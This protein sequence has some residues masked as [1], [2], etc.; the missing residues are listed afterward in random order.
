MKKLILVT[1]AIVCFT[2]FSCDSPARFDQP[3]P[4]GE[5]ILSSIPFQ[6]K[7]SYAS[8]DSTYFLLIND[9]SIVRKYHNLI[10]FNIDSL[11]KNLI[12]KGN[13]VEDTLNRQSYSYQRMGDSIIIRDEFMDTLF[14][15]DQD[16][17][18]KRYK[19]YYFVNRK[20]ENAGWE[21]F[22]LNAK[23]NSI[24]MS[25]VANTQHLDSLQEPSSDT[26]PDHHKI[27]HL[28]KKQFKHFL[29]H[30]G[31]GNTSTFYRIQ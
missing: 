1:S 23:R 20:D 8:S 17:V 24:E 6:L 21:L 15:F 27:Y 3:Q 9:F 31:F 11:D 25:T 26:G 18:L 28:E 19:G 14:L 16:H 29:R 13:T 7:G 2:F 12:V 4:D 5:P 22:Q 10:R 30:D